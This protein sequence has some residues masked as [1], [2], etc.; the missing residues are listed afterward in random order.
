MCNQQNS[1][2]EVDLSKYMSMY[3][4]MYGSM[5]LWHMCLV[6]R[7]CVSN[8]ILLKLNISNLR[9]KLYMFIM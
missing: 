8:N 7:L 6:E 1:V 9:N 3:G 2:K 4:T 5:P